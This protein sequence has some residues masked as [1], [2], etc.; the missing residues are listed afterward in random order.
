[1]YR[2]NIANEKEYLENVQF[3]KKQSNGVVVL[4]T[5]EQ[6][7]GFLKGDAS[8]IY[9]LKG[10]GLESEYEVAELTELTLEQYGKELTDP[11]IEENT[12]LK[13]RTTMLEDCLLEMSEIVY[14]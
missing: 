13:E 9:A 10:C 12:Q 11:L 5:K 6:A 3:I 14:A 8:V 2:I 4:C 7:Q 1:M